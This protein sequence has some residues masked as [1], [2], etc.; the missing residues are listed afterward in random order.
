MLKEL[1]IAVDE[2]RMGQLSPGRNCEQLTNM[3]G[4]YSLRLSRN[5][6][7]VF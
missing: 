5:F 7:F 1:S 4:V 3:P 2:L 6:R